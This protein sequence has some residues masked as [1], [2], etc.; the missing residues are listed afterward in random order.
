[1]CNS[2]C[3][4]MVQGPTCAVVRVQ[5]KRHTAQ[6]SGGGSGSPLLVRRLEFGG[7]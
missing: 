1:M 5:S 3:T 6:H 2:M 4:A 7:M